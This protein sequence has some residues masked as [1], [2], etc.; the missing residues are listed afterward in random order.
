MKLKPDALQLGFLKV[1]H[2]TTMKDYAEKNGWQW[3]EGAPYEVLST[4]YLSFVH[5]LFL[6]DVEILL[7]AFYNKGI[8]RRTMDYVIRRTGCRNFFFDA[9]EK[10]RAD[11]TL[12][13]DRKTAYWFDW[14]ARYLEKDSIA[15][16]LLKFDFLSMAKTSRFPAWM[17][18]NYD[19]SRHLDAMNKNE[20]RF[21][22]RI[23][24]AFSEYDEFTVNPASAEPEKTRGTFRVLFV[25]ERHN[26][27]IINCQIILQ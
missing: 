6:K 11:G 26:S 15:L 9:A 4:P 14:L 1:L 3:M 12:D 23:E 19:K 13:A 27:S 22:G 7:D 10:A 2:G 5:I 18:H 21:D 25:Y 8:F 17:K 16:E 20:C 24:F